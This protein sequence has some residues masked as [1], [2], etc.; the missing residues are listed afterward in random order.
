MIGIAVGTFL[1]A[2][3]IHDAR[4]ERTAV[5]APPQETVAPFDQ[6]VA[7]GNQAMDEERYREAIEAYDRALTIR[8]DADVAT[9]RGICYR[10][11]NEPERALAGFEFVTLKD[12]AHWKARYN[13]AVVLLQLGRVDEARVEAERVAKLKPGEPAVMKLIEAIDQRR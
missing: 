2:P 12:P 8:F 6:A 10:L 3:I 9:D 13:R 7:A 1:I 11:L 5:P 4:R